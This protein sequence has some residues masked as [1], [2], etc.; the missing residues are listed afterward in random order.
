MYFSSSFFYSK[1]IRSKLYSSSLPHVFPQT[2]F[3]LVLVFGFYCMSMQSILSNLI[4]ML[5]FLTQMLFLMSCCTRSSLAGFCF[6]FSC[7]MDVQSP[8]YLL[9]YWLL[10]SCQTTCVCCYEC[11]QCC[12]TQNVH[13]VFTSTSS[14]RFKED[15]FF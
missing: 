13:R 15:N 8:L 1:E 3:F 10:L 9:L 2:F 14:A 12:N 7:S 11:H 4:S 5:S 6:L